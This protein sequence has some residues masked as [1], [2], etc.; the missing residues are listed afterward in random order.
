MDAFRFSGPLRKVL[1]AAH[2]EANRLGHEYIGTEHLL[3][4]L[5]AVADG[6]TATVLRQLA[7]T[8]EQIRQKVEETV[9]P[10]RVSVARPDLPYTSR[11]KQVFE[12]THAEAVRSQAAAAEPEHLLIGLCSQGRGIGAQILV[13]AG[14]TTDV[15][16]AE[17]ERFTGGTGGA[18]PD[19]G[20]RT[21]PG[22][23]TPA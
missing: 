20:D 5:L 23:S 22:G 2:R 4:A 1:A 10:G 16:R 14:L 11:T 3:L 19:E 7:T 17:V 6:V 12:L 8:P 13:W 9:I 18:P 21:P 15:A